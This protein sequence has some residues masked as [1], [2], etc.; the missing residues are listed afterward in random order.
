MRPTL[1]LAAICLAALAC[2]CNGAVTSPPPVTTQRAYDANAVYNY[3]LGRRYQAEGRYELAREHLL[4]A[5]AMSED[6]EL[7]NLV[8]RDIEAADKA[9]R[10]RR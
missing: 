6:E 3:A 8:V 5:L 7:R 1:L 4:Q 9:I 2:G 10:S